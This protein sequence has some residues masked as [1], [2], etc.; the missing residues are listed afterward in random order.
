[1]PAGI[2][3]FDFVDQVT[4]PADVSFKNFSSMLITRSGELADSFRIYRNSRIFNNVPHG[5]RACA[6]KH[7]H[8]KHLPGQIAIKINQVDQYPQL[9]MDV[10]TPFDAEQK[11]EFDRER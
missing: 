5:N 8:D 6:A 1:M 11:E 2:P 9:C 3:K 7:R 4:N 10:E